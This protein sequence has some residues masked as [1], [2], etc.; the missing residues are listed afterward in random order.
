MRG[1]EISIADFDPRIRACRSRP[2]RAYPPPP[3][4]TPL[5]PSPVESS[6]PTRS[7]SLAAAHCCPARPASRPHRAQVEQLQID[8]GSLIAP[9]SRA[10]RRGRSS[11]S[12][13]R[14]APRLRSA[15]S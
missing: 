4:H 9:P 12:A 15:A 13:S 14:S 5:R 6:R 3:R 11:E 1:G 7:R 2:L 8:P 10:R